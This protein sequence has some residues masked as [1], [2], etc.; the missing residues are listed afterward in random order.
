MSVPAPIAVV[1]VGGNAIIRAGQ[2]GT[3]DEQR[4]N[5]RPMAA[6]VRGLVAAGWRVVLVHGNGP[7]VGN[8]AIQQDAAGHQVPRLPLFL[9]DAMTEGQLGSLLALALH[10]PDGGLPAA[11]ALVTHVLVDEADPGFARPTKPV[12]PFMTAA[13]AQRQAAERGSPSARTP[14]ADTGGWWPRRA[15]CAS[16]S[17]TRCGALVDRG[18]IVIAAGGGGVPVV[19]DGACSGVEAVIDKDLAAQLLAR[20]SAP[21]PWC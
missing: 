9:L 6:A 12:G 11:V 3:G 20:P 8:L 16:W 7:Q 14:V 21:R 18:L 19:A 4:E 10:G 13:D 5:L 1:A 2:V 17:W 15:R